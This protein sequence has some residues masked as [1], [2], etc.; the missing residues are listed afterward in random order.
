[1]NPETITAKLHAEADAATM[2]RI[3]EAFAPAEEILSR[4]PKRYFNVKPSDKNDAPTVEI[5]AFHVLTAIKN[6]YFAKVCDKAR[7]DRVE[8]FIKRIES[9]ESQVEELAHYRD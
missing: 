5:N 2:K 8:S 9:L 1:M 4:C 7:T 6:A 3:E